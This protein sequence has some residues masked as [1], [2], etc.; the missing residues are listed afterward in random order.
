MNREDYIFRRIS[1]DEVE[2]VR[3]L[4]HERID[5][6]N[7]KGLH[8]WNE[9][10]YD[11]RFPLS[12]FQGEQQKGHVYGLFEKATGQIVC[13]GVMLE[14][15]FRWTDSAP[16][17]NLNNSE[18]DFHWPDSVPALYLHNLASSTRKKGSGGLFVEFAEMEA[19]LQGMKYLRLDSA[20][21]NEKLTVFYESRGYMPKGY[22]QHGLYHGI[23]REKEL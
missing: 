10:H 16:A 15:D 21:G 4:I 17:R 11:E 7:E 20:V 23:L 22:C 5:W 13:A 6:M 1:E 18:E 12:Y 8:Q 19:R 2:A 14:E 3:A 9:T